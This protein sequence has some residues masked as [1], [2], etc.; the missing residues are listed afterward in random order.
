MSLRLKFNLALI[1]AFA[2]GLAIA[3]AGLRRV[4]VEDARSE[5]LE[6]ARLM[7][8]SAAAIRGYTAEQ[9]EPLLSEQAGERFLPQSVPFF[10]AQ[11]N[12][13]ALQKNY[14]DYDYKE[15]ALNPTNPSDRAS[16]W[17]T[18]I[19]NIFRRDPSMHELVTERDSP[20]GRLLSLAHPLQVTDAACLSCHSTPAAAPPSMVK[21]YG[22]ANGFGW[23]SKDVVGASIVS[24]PMSVAL[25]RANRLFVVFMA[26]LVVVFLVTIVLLNLLL[27][28]MV[29]RPVVR[30][31]KIASEVSLG[32]LDAEEYERKGRDEIASL[33]ASFNRM[34]RSLE[35]AIQLLEK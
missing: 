10:A 18:D 11:A 34:R 6:N 9:I 15:A 4:V 23:K 7:M 33:S 1:L 3:A 17:E 35:Q 2:V 30:M 20:T 29:V 25:D 16:D 32:N 12:F 28:Y 31:S 27:Q 24:V 13:R 8:Q 5:V 21:L 14:P 19:I 22:T 26:V